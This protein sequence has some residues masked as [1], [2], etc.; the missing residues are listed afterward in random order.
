MIKYNG[1]NDSREQIVFCPDNFAS[2]KHV[3]IMILCILHF[4]V[5]KSEL[6]RFLSKYRRKSVDT[7][8]F[9]CGYFFVHY[10]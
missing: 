9:L 1:E 3:H 8:A 4:V 7:L 5:S 6:I 10:Y 2:E